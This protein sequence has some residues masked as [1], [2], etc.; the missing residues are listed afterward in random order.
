MSSSN[1]GLASLTLEDDGDNGCAEPGDR[2]PA[3][4][5]DVLLQPET[6]VFMEDGLFVRIASFSESREL[7]RLCTL[8]K[9]GIERRCELVLKNGGI[10]KDN[11][12]LERLPNEESWTTVLRER[13][14]LDKELVF[15]AGHASVMERTFSN[16]VFFPPSAK[17]SGAICGKDQ[18]MRTG[19]HRATFTVF[20]RRICFHVGILGASVVQDQLRRNQHE[21]GRADG[22]SR[23]RI[24]DHHFVPSFNVPLAA[25][26]NTFQFGKILQIGLEVDIE[27]KV[28]RVY[29]SDNVGTFGNFRL[30]ES[31]SFEYLSPQGYYWALRGKHM[32]RD[33][34]KI[35]DGMEKCRIEREQRPFESHVAANPVISRRNHSITGAADPH[36]VQGHQRNRRQASARFSSTSTRQHF[37]PYS[38]P[39]PSP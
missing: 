33:L 6:S 37:D 17:W 36:M 29:H 22:K 24:V 18:I 30:V 3:P 28:M 1:I 7:L 26:H 20:R 27:R 23:A 32:T 13:I 14:A 34:K 2:K 21:P 25:R 8:T 9:E 5:D 12:R 11:R 4:P 35:N 10:K 16:E 39:P 15:T 38:S 19:V 31:I